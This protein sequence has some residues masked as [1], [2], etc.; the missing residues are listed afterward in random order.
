MKEWQKL[1]LFLILFS[2]SLFGLRYWR[3]HS[4][5]AAVAHTDLKDSATS[6]TDSLMVDR[7]AN[8][9]GDTTERLVTIS[10]HILDLLEKRDFN[11][12]VEFVHP[13][14]KL[15]FSPYAHLDNDQKSFS[16]KE[17]KKIKV[18]DIYT[19]GAFDGSG[20][21]ITM[22]IDAY[23]NRFVLDRP[24]IDSSQIVVNQIGGKGNSIDNLNDY[25]PNSLNVSYF[26]KGSAR[27][28]EM[29]W[30]QLK[31]AF[32]MKGNKVYLVAIVHDEWT[33]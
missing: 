31:L 30:R 28:G 29:D 24:Y 8:L 11:G 12:I 10:N 32:E 21:P 17:L 14:S 25:F 13:D 18:S 4:P 19:W 15:H 27:Y 1:L 26:V 6:N 33:V 2:S 16:A 5:K 7:W 22:S 20:D 9:P 3:E 23:F